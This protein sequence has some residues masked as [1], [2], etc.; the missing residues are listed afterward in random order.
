MGES[1]V[2]TP[3][4]VLFRLAIAGWGA[5]GLVTGLLLVTLFPFEVRAQHPAQAA[6]AVAPS[7]QAPETSTAPPRSV[8]VFA[9]DAGMVLNFIKPDKTTDFETI[10]TRLKEALQ[11]SDKPERKHQ[12][13]TWKV[14]RATEPGDGTV[15]YVFSID[16][17]VKGADYT[18]S[19]ILA[20]FPPKLKRCTSS[21][22]TRTPPVRTSST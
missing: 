5:A 7:E 3:A 15:L 17:A 19:T 2:A 9:S 21:T 11:K 6:S 22:R 13:A 10:V 12:A 18:V 16:P 4:P 20:D 14:F 8:R 1:R